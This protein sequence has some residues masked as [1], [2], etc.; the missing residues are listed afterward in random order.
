MLNLFLNQSIL[1]FFLVMR[2]MVTTMTWIAL[3]AFENFANCALR[4]NSKKQWQ[5]ELSAARQIL[6]SRT[7]IWKQFPHQDLKI[8]FTPV[9][10]NIFHMRLDFLEI[11]VHTG[12]SLASRPGNASTL[13]DSM[14]VKIIIS[15][16]SHVFRALG[17]FSSNETSGEGK[18]DLWWS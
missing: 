9:Y 13:S 4:W 16:F 7:R 6:T 10:K 18:G 12:V 8:F 14:K 11:F 1:S 15:F 17:L 5:Y 2:L 3:T